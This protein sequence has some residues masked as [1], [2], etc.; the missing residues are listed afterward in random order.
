LTAARGVFTSLVA[1]GVALGKVL[2]Y[3]L[4]RLLV[5]FRALIIHDRV[6]PGVVHQKSRTQEE[7]AVVLLFYSTRASAASCCLHACHSA[8]ARAR[9]SKLGFLQIVTLSF[10]LG[11]LCH[12]G[13]HTNVSFVD[14]CVTTPHIGELTLSEPDNHLPR[15]FRNTTT[16][17][18]SSAC[19]SSVADSFVGPHSAGMICFPVQSKAFG[20]YM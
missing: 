7:F 13:C 4:S 18:C 3:D 1:V 17:V 20:L 5:V 12:D 10:L 19:R 6:E 16:A 11:S 15:H 8:L 9:S 14:D 2:R